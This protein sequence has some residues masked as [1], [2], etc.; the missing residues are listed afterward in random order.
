MTLKKL[1]SQLK[2]D[3]AHMT[4]ACRNTPYIHKKQK[5]LPLFYACSCSDRSSHQVRLVP[6]LVPKMV[7]KLVPKAD[8][9]LQFVTALFASLCFF[10]WVSWPAQAENMNSD[11]YSIQFG[12][13]NITAGEKSGPNYKVTDTVGQTG[14]GPYGTFG[15]S[16][17][18][19][20]GG[21]QYIYQIPEFEFSLSAL[22]VD[23]GQ[24][25][26]GNHATQNHTMTITTRGANGYTVYVIS[27]HPLR[28]QT[29]SHAIPYTSCD[30]GTCTISAAG[31]WTNTNV[32][33]FG[34]NMSGP[35]VPTDFT[36]SSFFR[37]F[38]DREAAQSPQVVMSSPDIANNETATITYQAGI[39]AN[40]AAGS[41]QTA[42][43]FIAVPGY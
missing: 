40:Q 29:G 20:G 4:T 39:D 15:V 19:I 5:M 35:T 8:F 37:P 31:N 34:Y 18:F 32:P 9:R 24:L 28:H 41:Y 21:F 43:Q 33:G 1:I 13:F 10:I 7:P 22:S 6:K 23:F 3:T 25:L 2:K 26:I 11:S 27:E 30:A 16:N 42:I 36:S 17:Y 38:P 12:N 14:A